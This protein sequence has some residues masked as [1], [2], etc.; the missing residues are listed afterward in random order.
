[1]GSYAGA[2]PEDIISNEGELQLISLLRPLEVPYKYTMNS[3]IEE[4]KE[5]MAM[6]ERQAKFLLDKVRALQS[7]EA[8]V[9]QAREAVRTGMQSWFDAERLHIKSMNGRIYN[10]NEPVLQPGLSAF[11]TAQATNTYFSA[12]IDHSATSAESFSYTLIALFEQE[13]GIVE[14]FRELFR[15]HE[16]LVKSIENVTGRLAKAEGGKASN[17]SEQI[18]EYKQ[19]LEEKVTCLNAF[20]KGFSYITLPMIARHRAAAC[21]RLISCFVSSQ[22]VQYVAMQQICLDFF[23][24]L[25]ISSATASEEMRRLYGTVDA[26]PLARVPLPDIPNAEDMSITGMFLNAE[27][28]GL[29]GLFQRALV[30][31]KPPT[32]ASQ[33]S[34]TTH[35]FTSSVHNTMM[36]NAAAAAIDRTSLGDNGGLAPAPSAGTG[37]T[38]RDSFTGQSGNAANPLARRGS[39]VAKRGNFL[40]SNGIASGSSAGQQQPRTSGGDEETFV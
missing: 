12:A 32:E 14:S 15:V 27:Q 38:G 34:S 20:Y 13:L 26:K 35:L 3:R 28:T 21:R 6:I 17:R 30:I 19:S 4:I 22:Q 31:S 5:E 16:E 33:G 18:Q 24:T 2:L 23:Q 37:T 9:I 40:N 36:A 11:A 7:C 1:M 8:A 39:A 25:Q 29:S 10:E